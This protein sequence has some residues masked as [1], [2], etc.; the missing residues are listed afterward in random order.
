[1]L[2]CT[3]NLSILKNCARYVSIVHIQPA[4]APTT[5]NTSSRACSG[6]H[7]QASE[8]LPNHAARLSAASPTVSWRKHLD[9]PFHRMRFRLQGKTTSGDNPRNEWKANPYAN[10]LGQKAPG[11]LLQNLKPTSDENAAQFVDGAVH[12]SP[13]RW[14]TDAPDTVERLLTFASVPLKFYPK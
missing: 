3:L 4:I 9:K 13:G 14:R 11:L 6:F 10:L 2:I 5:C 12:G 7:C 8:P 1:M